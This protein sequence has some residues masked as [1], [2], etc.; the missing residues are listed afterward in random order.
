GINELLGSFPAEDGHFLI[1]EH[2]HPVGNERSV[3]G[4]HW[5]NPYQ[6]RLPS[7]RI[8]PHIPFLV[9][10][11]PRWELIY[12]IDAASRLFWE[13]GPRWRS[14]QPASRNWDARPEGP[15]FPSQSC[16]PTPRFQTLSQASGKPR[17]IAFP[18]GAS[19]LHSPR[20][21]RRLFS[22]WPA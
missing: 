2:R 14:G 13:T 16:L 4:G 6:L 15:W 3:L 22:S 21:C 10:P 8:D 1:D 7:L 19:G 20:R 12:H 9:Q 5:F 18:S 17:R 11:F